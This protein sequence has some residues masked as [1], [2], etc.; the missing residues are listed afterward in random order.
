[1]VDTPGLRA[2]AVP[3]AGQVGHGARW[4]SLTFKEIL[5][6]GVAGVLA[7]CASTPSPYRPEQPVTPYLGD[8]SRAD[9]ER[10]ARFADLT[11][12]RYNDNTPALHTAIARSGWSLEPTQPAS[13]W[14]ELA[15]WRFAHGRLTHSD[16][17]IGRGFRRRWNCWIVIHGMQWPQRR[18]LAGEMTRILGRE[19]VETPTGGYEWTWSPRPW[20]TRRVT[21]EGREE[22]RQLDRE[23]GMTDTEISVSDSQF[24]VINERRR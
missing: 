4:V 3:E 20:K 8:A 14:N 19:P 7:G 9:A 2:I 17:Q 16:R 11:C 6:F 13:Y 15:V 18:S 1:M 21:I 23:R 22:Q 5:V 24:L 12:L 10:A